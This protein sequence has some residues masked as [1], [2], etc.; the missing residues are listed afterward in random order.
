[1]ISD[2]KLDLIM[3]KS[4][5]GPNVQLKGDPAVGCFCLD[6]VFTCF[7]NDRPKTDHTKIVQTDLDSP[8]QEQGSTVT[9]SCNNI[10]SC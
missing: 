1:M 9:P 3:T 5:R 2:L 7:K 8:C 6:P 4:Q 10:Y